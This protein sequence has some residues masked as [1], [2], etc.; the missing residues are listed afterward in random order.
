MPSLF[1]VTI[2]REIQLRLETERLQSLDSGLLPPNW[3][4][5]FVLSPN[6]FSNKKN[7]FDLVFK[8]IFLKEL[9][10]LNSLKLLNR[11]NKPSGFFFLISRSFIPICKY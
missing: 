2:V 1:K 7:V 3:A 9:T 11:Y 10:K 6:Q 4:R 5:F 8:S